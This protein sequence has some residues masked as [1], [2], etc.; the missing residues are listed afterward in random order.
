MP[1]SDLTARMHGSVVSDLG[2]SRWLTYTLP[3]GASIRMKCVYE[4]PYKRQGVGDMDMET[5]VVERVPRA[6]VRTSDFT[7][8]VP[9][10]TNAIV[11]IDDEPDV[12]FRVIKFEDTN[13]GWVEMVL[14]KM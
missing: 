9:Q 5:Y 4:S 8:K 6:G 13:T 11:K 12:T 1:W 14:E 2:P 3:N 7:A 10:K